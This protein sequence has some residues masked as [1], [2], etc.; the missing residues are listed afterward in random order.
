MILITRQKL[1][2]SLEEF[3]IYSTLL[4]YARPTCIRSTVWNWKV[5]GHRFLL[6]TCNE[7][8]CFGTV[9]VCFEVEANTETST[10]DAQ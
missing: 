5:Y 1:H 10:P 2:Y 3:L 9:F 8:V 6:S 4:L 7:M